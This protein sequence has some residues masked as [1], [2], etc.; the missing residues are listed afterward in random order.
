M[1]KN[2]I[3]FFCGFG[4]AISVLLLNLSLVERLVIPDICYYHSHDT[5]LL[6]DVFYSFPPAQGGH[7]VTSNFSILLSLIIGGFG[8]FYFA[9]RK[10]MRY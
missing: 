9:K 4:G 2:I 6:F 8:A 10:M 5:T 3:Y 7:P 1:S